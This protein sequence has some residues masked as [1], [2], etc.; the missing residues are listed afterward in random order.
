MGSVRVYDV[1]ILYVFTMDSHIDM[2]EI[3]GI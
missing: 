3:R 1:S 2:L